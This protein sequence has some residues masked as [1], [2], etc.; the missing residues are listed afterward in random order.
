MTIRQSTSSRSLPLHFPYDKIRP[1]QQEIVDFIEGCLEDKKI[2]MIE[3]ATGVGKTI[4]A[5]HHYWII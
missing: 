2:G 1:Q 4:A 3:A 5:L